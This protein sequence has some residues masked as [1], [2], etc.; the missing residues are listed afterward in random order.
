[1]GLLLNTT[2]TFSSPLAAGLL[3]RPGTLTGGAPGGGGGG[4]KFGMAGC[5]ARR[6]AASNRQPKGSRERGK[7]TGRLG[8]GQR[9]LG[10]WRTPA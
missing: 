7:V 10:R 9:R 3:G 4:V 5:W 8:S 6:P 1:M 2:R